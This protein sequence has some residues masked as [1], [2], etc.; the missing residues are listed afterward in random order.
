MQAGSDDRNQQQPRRGV[1]IVGGFLIVAGV[2]VAVLAATELVLRISFPQ[3]GD[4]PRLLRPVDSGDSRPYLLRRNVRI[5]FWGMRD[6]M[7]NPVEWRINAEGIR[8]DMPIPRRSGKYRIVTFGDSETFGW[9]VPIEQTFQRL[10]ERIDPRIEVINLAVPGYNV[11]NVADHVT[12]QLG[13]IQ[14]DL[15]IYLF[16]KNDIDPPLTMSPVLAKS[17]TWI[18]LRLLTSQLF[19][20]D[21][22]RFRKTPA[23]FKFFADQFARIAAQCRRADTPLLLGMLHWRYRKALSAELRQDAYIVADKLPPLANRFRVNTVNLRHGWRNFPKID[24]HLSR[25]GHQDTARR[26]CK[27]IAA[28][29]NKACM[30]PGW[31]PAM[32][33]NAR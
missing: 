28:G 25:P 2:V 32:R 33:G 30:P 5:Q 1:R 14:P 18:F 12:E 7:K 24:R 23:G 16:H 17:Y 10:M 27:V 26:L 11:E 21:R 6:R 15:V 29:A 13:Q 4:L 8:S 20:R 3:F 22:K 9:A 31:T 19:S